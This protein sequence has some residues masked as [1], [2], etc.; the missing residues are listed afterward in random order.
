MYVSDLASGSQLMSFPPVSAGV[1]SRAL[2]A[3]EKKNKQKKNFRKVNTKACD[4]E[5]RLWVTREAK[6]K[7]KEKNQIKVKMKENTL[8]GCI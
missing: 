5:N 8:R 6:Q 7:K 3:G 1:G 2:L 4:D